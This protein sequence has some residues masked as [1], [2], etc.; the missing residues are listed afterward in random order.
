M[1][2]RRKKLYTFL[3]FASLLRCDRRR[4]CWHRIDYS[5]FNLARLPG[6]A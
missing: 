5:H 3:S 1:A 4:P 2:M 6:F